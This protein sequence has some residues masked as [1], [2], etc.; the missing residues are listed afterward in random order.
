M[1]TT[2]LE[3][4]AKLIIPKKSAADENNYRRSQQVH[5]DDLLK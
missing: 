3:I 4:L 1:I 2:I 5:F